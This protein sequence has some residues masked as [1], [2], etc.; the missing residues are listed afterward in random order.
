[1]RF[2]GKDGEKPEYG[3]NIL[4]ITVGGSSGMSF[5]ETKMVKNLKKYLYIYAHN[6]YYYIYIYI[7]KND[8]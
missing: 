4:K 1:M 8:V 7:L 3:D 2:A 5:E 6:Y